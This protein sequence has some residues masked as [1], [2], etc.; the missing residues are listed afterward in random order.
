MVIITYGMSRIIGTSMLWGQRRLILKTGAPDY[1]TLVTSRWR[2]DTYEEQ[3]S[4]VFYDEWID[5]WCPVVNQLG[6]TTATIEIMDAARASGDEVWVYTSNM[7]VQDV[8][9]PS[10]HI[11]LPNGLYARILPWLAWLWNLDGILYFQS[12]ASWS[13]ANPFED[14]FEYNGN[15][16]VLCDP[17]STGWIGGSHGTP[18]P[19]LRL[20]YI[21]DGYEDYEYL[22]LLYDG[23]YPELA[24]SIVSQIIPV[25]RGATEDNKLLAV[26]GWS[27]DYDLMSSLR[28]QMADCL[29]GTGPCGKQTNFNQSG[30]LQ[31][32]QTGT[33][34]FNQ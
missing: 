12:D 34:N 21:R 22:K 17:G 15:G 13:N 20:K 30:A 5:I 25:E 16:D 1:R 18:V 29:D 7:S 3:E 27:Q 19:S 32:D 2:T 8:N 9:S 23:G 11:D 14:L 28:E 26:R 31:F 6:V 4:L 24:E 10:W 33:L